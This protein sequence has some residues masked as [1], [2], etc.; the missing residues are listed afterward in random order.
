MALMIAGCV[1]KVDPTKVVAKVGNKVYS[2][3][4]IDDRIGNLD[5]QVQQFFNNKEQKNRLLDQIIDEEIL[6]QMAKKDGI[7]RDQEFKDFF[8]NIERQAV[9]NFYVQKNVDSLSEVTEKEVEDFYNQNLDQFSEREDRCLSHILVSEE[10]TAN[11]VLKKIKKGTGFETL[12]AE[13]S[14]DRTGQTGG[15]LG[16]V[17]KATLD[18]TFSEAEFSLARKNQ[19]SGVV[20]TQFGFHIIRYDDNKKIPAKKLD[21]VYDQISEQLTGQ[22]K[23]DKFQEI[24]TTGKEVVK[25]EKMEDNLK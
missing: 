17:S 24:L 6:Y 16:C 18:P 13:F 3:D 19:I 1:N 15:S 21:D 9:I 4:D 25:V 5:A 23:R 7:K 8:E 14:I 20:K 10:A 22:K 12:A 11:D 2:V